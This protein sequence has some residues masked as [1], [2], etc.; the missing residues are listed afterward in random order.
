ME[1]NSTSKD[2][3]FS[4]ESAFQSFND[5][6]LRNIEELPFL[7][8]GMHKLK[9]IMCNLLIHLANTILVPIDTCHLLHIQQC[10]CEKFIII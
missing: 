10:M 5:A 8:D 6:R 7:L 2:F 4:E 3:L 1:S 9:S